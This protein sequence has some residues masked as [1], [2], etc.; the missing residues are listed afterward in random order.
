MKAVVVPTPHNSTR[1]FVQ[2]SAKPVHDFLKYASAWQDMVY[3]YQGS[4]WLGYEVHNNLIDAVKYILIARGYD[5]QDD[6]Q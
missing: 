4:N 6:F 3:T 2:D 5:I 1:V